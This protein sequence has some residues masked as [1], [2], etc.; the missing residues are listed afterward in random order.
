MLLGLITMLLG[1][2]RSH[3]CDAIRVVAEFMVNDAGV[4]AKPHV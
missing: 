2:K 4:E 3:T 1:L